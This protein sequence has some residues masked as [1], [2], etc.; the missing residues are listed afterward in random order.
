MLHQ[1]DNLNGTADSFLRFEIFP[2]SDKIISLCKLWFTQIQHR[3]LTL[4]SQ[5]FLVCYSH[6]A[7]DVYHD[8]KRA[9]LHFLLFHNCSYFMP[10]KN[11][12]QEVSTKSQISS[13][14]TVHL[15]VDQARGSLSVTEHRKL[16]NHTRRKKIKSS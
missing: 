16:Q 1:G 8:K 6:Q 4:G 3:I 12:E 14:L 11:E 10:W 9:M 2:F 13:V 7:C 5:V 15:V